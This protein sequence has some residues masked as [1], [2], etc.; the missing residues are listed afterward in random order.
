VCAAHSLDENPPMPI[1]QPRR[2]E[3]AIN[4]GHVNI[5]REDGRPLPAYWSHPETG[6]RFPAVALLH[7]WWG[8]TALERRLANLLAQLGYYV[9]VPDLFNGH[10]AATAREALTLVQGLG[11]D[12]FPCVNTTLVTLEHHHRTNGHVAAIGLGMGGSLAF[13]AAVER[14]DLE[15]AVACYGFPNRF[16]GRFRTAKTP[17]LALYGE[18]EPHVPARSIERLEGEFATAEREQRCIRLP[19]TGRD[20]FDAPIAT[21]IEDLET[22]N[23]ATQAW[24]II[25][26]FLDQYLQRPQR[27]ARPAF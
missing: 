19:G 23:I 7:D 22:A 11:E 27:P 2:V 17:I 1:Y 15:A 13:E 14:T 20:V 12:G 16:F 9:I 10:T 8:I 6:S 21:T 25:L 4:Q 3:Y 18:H 5:M 26:Q 24:T